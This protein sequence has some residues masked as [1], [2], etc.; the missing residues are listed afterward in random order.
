[1]IVP[2]RC[3]MVNVTR[4]QVCVCVPE[5]GWVRIVQYPNVVNMEFY[6]PMDPV[7]LTNII[8]VLFKVAFVIVL[9]HCADPT[10][11]VLRINRQAIR[12]PTMRWVVLTWGLAC[13]KW[14]G[15]VSLVKIVWNR[16]VNK[17]S[18]ITNKQEQRCI[19]IKKCL[20]TKV[21]I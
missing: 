18:K 2:I 5:H 8:T 17:I 12:V 9:V 10:I 13:V 14:G 16:P 4:K 11:D 3:T 21:C 15:P 7:V 19:R 1:M 6:C 20:C